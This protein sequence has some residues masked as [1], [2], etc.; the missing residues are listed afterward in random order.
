MCT[1][2][3]VRACGGN[4]N[5]REVSGAGDRMQD[6]PGLRARR[7]TAPAHGPHA[8]ARFRGARVQHGLDMRGRAP[9]GPLR[10]QRA[11]GEHAQRARGSGRDSC[12]HRRARNACGPQRARIRRCCSRRQRPGQLKRAAKHAQLTSPARH[13]RR[14]ERVPHRRQRG[15]PMHAAARLC[16]HLKRAP[17]QQRR[18]R[19]RRRRAGSGRR[20]ERESYC[21]RAKPASD[22]RPAPRGDITRVFS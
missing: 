14:R 15:L 22:S 6:V 12:G 7:R 21:I 1:Q 18:H 19:R 2:S 20:R 8:S 16:A 10:R 17:A 9:H 5:K 13:M 3:A 4:K 11:R